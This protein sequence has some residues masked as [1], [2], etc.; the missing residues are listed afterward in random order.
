MPEGFEPQNK[1][2]KILE[3]RREAFAT[4][5]IDWG[6]AETLAFAT[7]IQDGT[8]V[9]FTGQDAQRGTFS[10]RHLVLHDKNN[11]TDIYTITS[12]FRCKSII[13]CV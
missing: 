7:I 2:G 12:Y 3:K 13:H 11:G 6:H 5:K 9:R 10:Q 4:E 8:P 1:L